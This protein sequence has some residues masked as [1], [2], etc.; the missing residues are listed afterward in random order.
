[1]SLIYFTVGPTRLHP[2]FEEFVKKGMAE[3]IGS[4]SHRSA[5]FSQLFGDLSSNLKKLLNVP[6]EYSVFYSGSATEF[7][8][9][10]VQNC[11]TKETLHFVNGSFSK[12]F[13]EIAEEL[14]RKAIRVPARDDYS[15]SA[16]DIPHGANPELVCLTHNETSSGIRLPKEFVEEI[17]EK[18]KDKLIAM[19][20]VSSAPSTEV[21]FSKI[22]CV[23]FSV[24]K[25]FGL[26]AGLGI[27]FVSPKALARSREIEATGKQYMGSYH[28]F[29]S[30][31]KSAEKNQTPETP[32][33]FLMYL[34][35]EI[36][37]DFLSRGLE[38]IKSETKEKAEMIYQAL[39]K[40]STLSPFIKNKNIQSETVIVAEVKDG[41]KKIIEKIKEGGFL[42]A[43]GYADKK[44]TQVRIGNFPSHTKEQVLKLCE[45]IKES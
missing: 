22:D 13:S 37:L 31:A 27:I 24:Q 42:I 21:D 10:I 29:S 23:F 2:K 28:S 8:E 20:I 45:L 36:V 5:R 11:S 33:V 34:L 30:F 41:S 15:F 25:G 39:E 43:G 6:E 14:G 16:E 7:M 9:R 35:N 32:N 44:E 19:D 4:I 17:Q 3:N 26:P 1:M 38:K 40:S 12:K 18:Y